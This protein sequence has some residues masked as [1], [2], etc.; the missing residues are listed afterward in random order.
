M[1]MTIRN[2]ITKNRN[3]KNPDILFQA[4][5]NRDFQ[6]PMKVVS[7]QVQENLASQDQVPLRMKAVIPAPVLAKAD[8]P[9]PRDQ[10]L[11]DPVQGIHAVLPRER[12]QAPA[13]G[14][15]AV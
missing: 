9:G 11:Q 14:I 13:Q 10:G 15:H 6:N 5:E 8:I 4:L 12:A 1:Q 7:V 2:L 3:L